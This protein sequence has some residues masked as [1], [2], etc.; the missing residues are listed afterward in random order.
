MLVHSVDINIYIPEAA[1][2]GFA[3]DSSEGPEVFSKFPSDKSKEW[4]DISI[5]ELLGAY[6][7]IREIERKDK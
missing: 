4:N 3:V 7:D 1:K 2:N 5:F 6:S